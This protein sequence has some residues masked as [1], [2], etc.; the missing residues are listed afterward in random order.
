MNRVS[1]VKVDF[2]GFFDKLIEQSR[3]GV[4]L[5]PQTGKSI[6]DNTIR[7]YVTTLRHLREF[8]TTDT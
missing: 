5:N 4:R 1:E 6:T 2:L 7:T 8:S 3:T